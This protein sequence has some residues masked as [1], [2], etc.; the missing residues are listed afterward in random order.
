[1]NVTDHTCV[2]TGTPSP[3][4][5][6]I[7]VDDGQHRLITTAW[8]AGKR[9]GRTEQVDLSPII[10]AYR[11]YRPLRDNVALFETAH[12]IDDGF[13]VA[14]GDGEIDMS[15][16]SIERLAE[17]AMT[18]E[19]FVAFLDRNS[20][21][22]QAAAAALGRS[23]RQIEYYLHQEQLPRIVALACIGYEVRARSRRLVGRN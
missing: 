22:H 8:A 23:K 21:T 11:V 2:D 6:S 4:I 15:A 13:A 10:D 3:A 17:E 14:W 16:A 19:D 1:M 20:L 7:V 9:Q 12:V 5:G 18:G